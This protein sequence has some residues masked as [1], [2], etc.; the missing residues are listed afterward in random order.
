MLIRVDR[1]PRSLFVRTL[2]IGTTLG[3]LTSAMQVAQAKIGRLEEEEIRKAKAEEARIAEKRSL[4]ADE[5]VSDNKDG[6]RKSWASLR[7]WIPGPRKE[8]G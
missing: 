5:A 4:G 7:A 6:K 8:E 3:G 1:L 2:I